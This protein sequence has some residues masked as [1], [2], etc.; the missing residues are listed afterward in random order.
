MISWSALT[1][2]DFSPTVSYLVPI[3]KQ[4]S[5]FFILMTYIQHT[6]LKFWTEFIW[7][8]IPPL[9]HG[10]MSF[11]LTVNTLYI[12]VMFSMIGVASGAFP[13]LERL[14]G[15]PSYLKPQPN[16]FPRYQFFLNFYTIFIFVF[17]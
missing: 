11:F 13:E 3:W 16:F 14:Q 17:S 15:V 8:R 2:W 7:K 10:F 1:K 5:G 12:S 9:D 6:L 4:I